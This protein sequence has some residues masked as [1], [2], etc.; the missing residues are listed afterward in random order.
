MS[1]WN[2]RGFY[3]QIDTY[4]TYGKCYQ[5]EP[6]HQLLLIWV[7]DWDHAFQEKSQAT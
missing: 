5:G 7:V 1:Y 4:D 2:K 6:Q 3:H